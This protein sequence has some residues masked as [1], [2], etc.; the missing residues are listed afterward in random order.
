MGLENSGVHPLPWIRDA[1]WRDL[2][3]VA[4]L[5]RGPVNYGN[6]ALPATFTRPRLPAKEMER[7]W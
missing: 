2:F 3:V 5:V 6:G 7:R 4:V 1:G